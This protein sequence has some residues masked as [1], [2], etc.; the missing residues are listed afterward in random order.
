MIWNGRSVRVFA[1]A[2]PT[3]LRKGYDGLSALVREDLGRDPTSGDLFVFVARNR[4]RAKVLLF[5]GT[6]LC[7]LAKRLED[8]RFACLWERVVGAEIEL[9]QA[10]L[11]LL[12]EGCELVGRRRLSPRGIDPNRVLWGERNDIISPCSTSTANKTPRPSASPAAPTIRR[13]GSSSRPSSG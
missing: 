4:V 13:T 5:D 2:A 3:D 6:G 1:R 8:G 9:T 7:V 10:E 11:Q 12:L